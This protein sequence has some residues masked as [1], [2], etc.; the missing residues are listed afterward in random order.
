[1]IMDGRMKEGRRLFQAPSGRSRHKGMTSVSSDSNRGRKAHK[2]QVMEGFHVLR[3]S[4][5][6][7]KEIW[8]KSGRF[9]TEE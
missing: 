6:F 4:D 2:S 7:L 1:M 9:V 5:F 3:N 8:R